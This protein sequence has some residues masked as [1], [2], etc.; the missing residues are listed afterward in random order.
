[1]NRS[2]LTYTGIYILVASLLDFILCGADKRRA[3]LGRWRI[4]EATL[5]F[6]GLIGGCFGLLF[7]MRAFRH[8][9]KHLKFTI[10]VP[11][12][13]VLWIVGVIYLYSLFYR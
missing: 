6:I 2:M 8:K 1:M 5:L 3:K 12:E 4:S 11:L 10:L 13:C 9:T 7:G